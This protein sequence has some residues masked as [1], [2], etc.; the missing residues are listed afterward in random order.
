V[1][2][3][4]GRRG[5]ASRRRLRCPPGR[6]RGG[7]ARRSPRRGW[8]AM[9]TPVPRRAGSSSRTR[10]SRTAASVRGPVQRAA[11][12]RVPSGRGRDRRRRPGPEM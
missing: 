12:G 3:I 2:K 5:A 1:D 6:S 4:D 7:S 9:S 10:P 11:R 8:A